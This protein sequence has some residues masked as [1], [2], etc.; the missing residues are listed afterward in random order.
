MYDWRDMVKDLLGITP[1]LLTNLEKWF[2]ESI[3]ARSS[4]VI[5]NPHPI[6]GALIARIWQRVFG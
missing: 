4:N 3:D 1:R 2:I 6:Q 5:W